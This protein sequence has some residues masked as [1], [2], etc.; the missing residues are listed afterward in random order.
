MPDAQRRMQELLNTLVREGRERGI[1]LAAYLDGTLVVDAFDGVA[2]PATNR[3]VDGETPFPVFSSTKGLTATLMHLLVERGKVA[4]DTPIAEYWP[5]F[6]ARGKGCI[7]VR[8]ALNHTA[9]LPFMPLGIGYKEL[10]DWDAMCAGL[11][12]LEPVSPPGEQMAYHAV[13][14]GWLVGETIRRVDG[15]SFARMLND[16]I[17]APLGIR[18]LF[19]GIPDEVEP[20]VAVLEEVFEP[21]KEPSFDDSKP[22]DVP[23]WMQPLHA[24][25]NRPDA[26]RACIPA[27]NGIMSARALARHYAALIPGGVNGVELLPA[28]RVRQATQLQKPTAN[29]GA[30]QPLRG[31]GYMLGGNI[32]EFGPSPTAFGHPG[33]GGSIGFADPECR[34]AVGLTKN[35]YSP[36]GAQGRVL[37]ELRDVLGLR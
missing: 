3:P 30:E 25:M 36:K 21:G 31:L 17:C 13:T 5:E 7:K 37:N 2:D 9:G 18:N 22:R 4:Y 1:Q 8:H 32:N 15:R 16:E 6:A 26:R 33:Y 27:S 29:A 10:C 19:V 14:Y 12:R 34:L 24:M 23:G 35:L 20:R 11:A 28:S